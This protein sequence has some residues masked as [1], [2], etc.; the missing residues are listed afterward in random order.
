MDSLSGNQSEGEK[1]RYFPA[2]ALFT[3]H[4]DAISVSKNLELSRVEGVTRVFR[5]FD[6][7]SDLK[8]TSNFVTGA[9]VPKKTPSKKTPA[10][11]TPA[12][13]PA[14]KKA[15]PKSAGP[16]TARKKKAAK[17]TSAPIPAAED[18]TP[19]RSVR[20]RRAPRQI[21][22]DEHER[23]NEAANVINLNAS[24]VGPPPSAPPG[25]VTLEQVQT[26]I[27]RER[28]RATVANRW[29]AEADE[30]KIA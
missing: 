21:D 13:A 29:R 5:R 14:K 8:P 23:E 9:M 10:K 25:H 26:L 4:L 15:P 7:K 6:L 17:R 18:P 20:D 16:A 28:D 24:G 30:A 1:N 19:R 12:K 22:E 2:K 11:K 3:S 27:E